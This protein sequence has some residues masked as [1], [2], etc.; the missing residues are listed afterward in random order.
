MLVADSM[1]RRSTKR[2]RDEVNSGLIAN[3][4]TSLGIANLAMI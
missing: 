2:S 1:Q 3:Y 4:F